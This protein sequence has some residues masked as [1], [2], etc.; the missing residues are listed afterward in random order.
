M[1][2]KLLKINNTFKPQI[3]YESSWL[4]YDDV[5]TGAWNHRWEYWLL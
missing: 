5:S 2:I 1:I 4:R 3:D